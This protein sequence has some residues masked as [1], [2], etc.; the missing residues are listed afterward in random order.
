MARNLQ[1]EGEL[2]SLRDDYAEHIDD[3]V[4]GRSKLNKLEAEVQSKTKSE[5]EDV[6]N[7]RADIEF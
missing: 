2:R 1:L 3:C 6:N 5:E 7:L 4:V